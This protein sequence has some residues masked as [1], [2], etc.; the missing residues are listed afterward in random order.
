MS[1]TPEA[2][3]RLAIVSFPCA[4]VASALAVLRVRFRRQE[5]TS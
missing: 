3:R 5:G 1:T 4:L 2:S